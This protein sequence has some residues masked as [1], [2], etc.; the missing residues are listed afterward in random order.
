MFFQQVFKENQLCSIRFGRT[1][2]IKDVTCTIFSN[3]ISFAY[4]FIYLS[5]ENFWNYQFATL[6]MNIEQTN[7]P[8][9]LKFGKHVKNG[10]KSQF[11]D[12]N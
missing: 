12:S 7:E 1:K 11:W 10:G 2:E 4:I 3:T 5:V 9:E 6:E 8:I